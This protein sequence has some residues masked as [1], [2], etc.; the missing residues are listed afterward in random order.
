MTLTQQAIDAIV[1]I[2]RADSPLAVDVAFLRWSRQVDPTLTSADRLAVT[3]AISRRMN[4][5][6]AT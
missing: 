4:A 1:Q 6:A 2:S 5:L 3:E